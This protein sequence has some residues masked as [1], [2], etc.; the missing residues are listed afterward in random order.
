MK[1]FQMRTKAFTY[2]VRLTCQNRILWVGVLVGMPSGH[3]GITM[4]AEN[5]SFALI[6]FAIFSAISMGT[7]LLAPSS[8]NN[9]FILTGEI[10]KTKHN[11]SFVHEIIET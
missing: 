2:A 1:G 8:K 5:L 9:I 7:K 4:Y 3:I 6:L 11:H 10:F